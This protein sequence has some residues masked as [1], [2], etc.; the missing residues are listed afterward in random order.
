MLFHCSRVRILWR[1]KYTCSLGVRIPCKR[2]G[3]DLT[4]PWEEEEESLQNCS[5]VPIL[6]FEQT[7]GFLK[8]AEQLDL[9]INLPLYTS[10]LVWEY[11]LYVILYH[12]IYLVFYHHL[13][14]VDWWF[15]TKG[16]AVVF[17]LLLFPF[18]L[19]HLYPCLLWSVCPL[20]SCCF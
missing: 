4:C 3:L 17:C 1:F 7:G 19:L 14:F 2:N 9:I 6:E 10:F 5:F 13:D 18:C 12:H 11:C 15:P 16:R 8:N 20:F